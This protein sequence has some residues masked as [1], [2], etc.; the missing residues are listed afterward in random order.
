VS[1]LEGMPYIKLT[2]LLFLDSFIKPD[3]AA[4]IQCISSVGKETSCMA[5]EKRADKQS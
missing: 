1:V 3:Q 2:S 5:E 4:I